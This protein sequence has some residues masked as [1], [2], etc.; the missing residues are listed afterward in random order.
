MLRNLKTAG[1]STPPKD[2]IEFDKLVTSHISCH[3]IAGGPLRFRTVD[4]ISKQDNSVLQF[5]PQPNNG[6]LYYELKVLNITRK[7][8][9]GAVGIGL[10]PPNYSRGMVGWKKGS[11]G[12]HADDGL[13]YMG[14]STSTEI[15]EPCDKEDISDLLYKHTE[16]E[17]EEPMIV[18]GE[19][20]DDADQDE[21]WEDDHLEGSDMLKKFGTN[22]VVG[23]YWN[24]KN[25]IVTFTLNGVMFRTKHELN[26]LDL[27]PT[28]TTDRDVT[29]S[30]N[31][32]DEPFLLEG[33][34]SKKN[35]IK[36]RDELVSRTQT[37]TF[38]DCS[39]CY[40]TGK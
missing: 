31:F 8:S 27:V 28:I 29:I 39:I 22:D 2:A 17:E 13:I 37:R 16:I 24:M 36:F 18:E 33:M 1:P 6:T 14:S 23:L 4:N 32:G 25:G 12:Y 15:Y 30:V 20:A 3:Q 34:L 7:S 9:D 40:G 21:E 10:A 19:E 35:I 26:D 5:T 38:S 11:I